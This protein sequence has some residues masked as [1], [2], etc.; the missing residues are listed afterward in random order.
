MGKIKRIFD[1]TDPEELEKATWSDLLLP[2]SLKNIYSDE[3][4]G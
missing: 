3:E 1:D 2:D 4:Y